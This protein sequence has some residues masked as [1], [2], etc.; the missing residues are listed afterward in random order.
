MFTYAVE[1]FTIEMNIFALSVVK[2]TVYFT[3][4]I[5]EFVGTLFIGRRDYKLPFK[6][7]KIM[8]TTQF[9]AAVAAG[10]ITTP[11]GEELYPFY[12]Q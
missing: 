6:L 8:T 1:T 7:C 3:L 12:N 10:G 2:F 4:V 5:S 11:L 9:G